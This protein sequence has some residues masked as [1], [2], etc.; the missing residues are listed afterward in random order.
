MTH[1]FLCLGLNVGAVEKM[2]M[3]QEA[4][5]HGL[6]VVTAALFLAGE[7]AGSG[8]LALPNAMIGTGESAVVIG[9]S[10]TP[11]AGVSI[12]KMYGFVTEY[13]FL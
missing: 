11:G 6:T 9:I 4:A 13:S 3:E 8:V 12:L 2:Q 5:K 7:M 10:L 1:F